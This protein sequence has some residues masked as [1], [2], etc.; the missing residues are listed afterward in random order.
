VKIAYLLNRR[1]MNRRFA[2]AIKRAPAPRLRAGQQ[3]HANL[4]RPGIF[5]RDAAAL[6]ANVTFYGGMAAPEGRRP[7]KTDY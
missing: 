7:L 1:D 5:F 2:H 3:N 4:S 6:R